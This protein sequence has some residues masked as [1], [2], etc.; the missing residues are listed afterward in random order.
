MS[1][2]LP[3]KKASVNYSN[4]P[5][6][7]TLALPMI[8]VPF[9]F[10][11]GMKDPVWKHAAFANDFTPFSRKRETVEK[12]SE[13]S[14]FYTETHLVIG[15][16]LYED[17]ANFI[18]QENPHSSAWA[19]DMV[20]IHFGGMEPDPWLYQTGLG[21][22]GN[23]FDS[24]G[25]YDKWQAY[26]FETEN[27]WGAEVKFDLSLLRLTEGGFRFEICRQAL[28]RNEFSCWSPLQIRFHEVE[29]FGELLLTDYKTALQMKTGKIITKNTVSRDDYEQT[30]AKEMIPAQTILHG[31]YLSCPERDSV[32]ISWETAGLVPSFLQYREK[33]SDQFHTVYSGKGNGILR[34]DTTHFVSL[35]GLIP[36]KEYEY[37]ILTLRPV[38]QEADFSGIRRTF[39]VPDADQNTFSF[40][41]IT[42]IHSNVRYLQKSLTAPGNEQCSF[43]ALLGDNLS[44]AAGREAL[45]KGIID[46][47]VAVNNRADLD[48]PLVF[49]RGNHEQLGVYAAEYFQV[50]RH[51]SGKT[52]Y[53]FTIG[54]T[55]FAV[56]DSGN[57]HPD[58]ADTHYFSN[59]ENEKAQQEFLT[60][61]VKTPAYQNAAFRVVMI[62]IPPTEKKE[63]SIYSRVYDH[64]LSPL[65]TA[66]IKPDVMLCGHMHQYER[67][68]ADKSGY[69]YST[70]PRHSATTET[71]IN[72]WPVIVNSNNTVLQCAV[73][74][75]AITIK[76]YDVLSAAEPVLL[77]TL[78]FNRK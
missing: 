16:F 66:E 42:D 26:T 4:N 52:Y 19:G 56:L 24:T 43:Y 57:D 67:V 38:T 31:P 59:P 45:Y 27:G 68:E 69:I 60:E 53:S 6:C 72:P 7:K 5:F 2:L 29:N 58:K 32:C 77:E 51:Y 76:V 75:Q 35:S 15:M 47:I 55:C 73:S 13:F 33:G 17:P 23:R 21:I 10:G 50:M 44:H 63:N 71:L 41:C 8:T 18:H 12:G 11:T 46:P 48:K 39:K 22:S 65:R 49:V 40:T 1:V 25:N 70:D 36:G 9:Q 30:M 37:E 14:V 28:K 34:H 78:T 3:F 61:L 74:D 54:N 20:E 64:I 62:H